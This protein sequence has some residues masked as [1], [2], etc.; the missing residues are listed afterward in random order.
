MPQ[1]YETA[2]RMLGVTENKILGPADL[3]LKQTADAVGC[4]YTFYAPR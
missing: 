1:H 2:S 3:L 4:G